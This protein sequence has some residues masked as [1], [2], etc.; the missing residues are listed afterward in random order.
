MQT[1][2]CD[3]EKPMP[4][5]RPGIICLGFFDGVHKGHQLL[6]HEGL[7]QAKRRG[8][9]GCVYTF[10]VPPGKKTGGEITPLAHKK[11][12]LEEMGVDI[13]YVDNFK[14]LKATPPREFVEKVLIE[15]LQAKGVVAGFN[16]TFGH[17]GEGETALLHEI[18][19]KHGVDAIEIPK[20]VIDGAGVSSRRIRK[21]INEGDMRAAEK[22][23]GRPFYIQEKVFAGKKLGRTM[24][25]PTINQSLPQN[26]VQMPLGVYVSRTTVEG[27]P[28]FSVTNVGKRPTVGEF[29]DITVETHIL[30]FSKDIYN[31]EI[32]VEFL[33]MLREEKK[34][35][36]LEELKRQM[37]K[38]VQ[39]V[40]D[41]ADK[42]EK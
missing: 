19:D 26:S 6:I 9:A 24:A 16:Y 7:L 35:D 12:I 34:F 32:K 10:D 40:A 11:E 5:T 20:I 29:D 18:L 25:I 4:K 28:Y 13:L 39:S 2:F 1:I 37:Q 31:Q 15:R 36:S 8:I 38:D 22:L 33:K 14:N 17:K 23:L 27:K 3:I 21:C 30:H 41:F 42:Y